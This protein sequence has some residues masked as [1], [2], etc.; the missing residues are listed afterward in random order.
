M[1]GLVGVDVGSWWWWASWEVA[2]AG[3]LVGR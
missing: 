1:G 3:G 2:G